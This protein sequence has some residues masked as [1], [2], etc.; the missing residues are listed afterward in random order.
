MWLADHCVYSVRRGMTSGKCQSQC[1]RPQ[2]FS[3]DVCIGLTQSVHIINERVHREINSIAQSG[4]EL[5]TS[6]G[7]LTGQNAAMS[8]GPP[9]AGLVHHLVCTAMEQ[10]SA[11][12]RLRAAPYA[13][14]FHHRSEPK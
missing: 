3:S 10:I 13:Q 6:R 2:V 12:T 14:A 9:F 8:S 7:A 5:H 11:V 1:P 4:F